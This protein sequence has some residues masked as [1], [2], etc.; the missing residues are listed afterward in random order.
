MTIMKGEIFPH[1]KYIPVKV[2][3]ACRIIHELQKR[4]LLELRKEIIEDK[5]FVIWELKT[6]TID[7]AELTDRNVGKW[8]V[9][10]SFSSPFDDSHKDRCRCTNCGFIHVFTDYHFG[11]YNFCPNCGAKMDG[12]R[13]QS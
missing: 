11:Q 8:E 13:C 5:L 9:L 10:E 12:E 6:E 4:N 3:V 2:E 1:C 7:V